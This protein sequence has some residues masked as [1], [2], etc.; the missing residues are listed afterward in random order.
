VWHQVA[1]AVARGELVEA[2]HRLAEFGARTY[3]AYVRLRAA[4]RLSVEG[5]AAAAEVQLER[6]LDFYRSVGA[7]PY[8]TRGERL[9]ATA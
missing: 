1:A 3:E 9:A 7:T 5:D 8:V 4:E 2:A 6:A